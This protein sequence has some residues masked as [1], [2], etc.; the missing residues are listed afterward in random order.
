MLGKQLLRAGTS[1]GANDRAAW[2]AL[3]AA[4]FQGKM[5]IVEEEAIESGD[6]IE[7]LTESSQVKAPRVS[8]LLKEADELTAIAVASH[9]TSRQSP[10]PKTR[11]P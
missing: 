9:K 3:S 5:G 6:W 1:I 8:N 7:H 2:R 4:E 10:R 11:K